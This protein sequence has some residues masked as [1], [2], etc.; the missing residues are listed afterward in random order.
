[1]PYLT[2]SEYLDFGFTEIEGT[3]F[4]KLLPKASDVIDS[5][6]RYFYRYNAIEKDVSFRREQFKKAI[7]AQI[8]YFH[9]LGAT[10]THELNTPLTVNLG[11]TQVSTGE[12]NQKK[13]N[14]LVAPD[15]YMYLRDTG[16]LYRGIGV[17]R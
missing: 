9:D 5:I 1:M 15:V 4:Q 3:E 10:S 8:E 7:G 17:V 12:A 13:V 6:T 2:Y 16:L 11:R 14:T